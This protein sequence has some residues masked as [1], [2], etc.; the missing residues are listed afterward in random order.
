VRAKAVLDNVDAFIMEQPSLI[1]RRARKVLLVV[2]QRT[3][4]ADHLARL[5]AQLGVESVAKSVPTLE[6]LSE[7]VRKPAH[8]IT[9]AMREGLAHE[10]LLSGNKMGVTVAKPSARCSSKPR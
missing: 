10:A 7:T 6:Y 9:E 5:L 1:N 4:L 3:R 2:E 8:L